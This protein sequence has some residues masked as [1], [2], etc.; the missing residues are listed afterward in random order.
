[1]AEGLLRAQA[2]GRFDVHSAGTVET[3]LRPEAVHVMAEIG[4]DISGQNSKTMN[5]YLNQKFDWVIT[6]CDDAREACPVLP[7]SGRS[8]HW[9]LPDPSAAVGGEEDRLRTFREVRDRLR[10]LIDGFLAQNIPPRSA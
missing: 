2:E 7:A 4:I 5:R 1:M 9:S 10:H 3:A 6:V 8:L